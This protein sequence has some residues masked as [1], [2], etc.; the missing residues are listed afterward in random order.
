[1]HAGQRGRA[2]AL[3][4]GV[5]NHGNPRVGDVDGF[6]AAFVEGGVEVLV[7]K[8]AGAGEA[9]VVGDGKVRGDADEDGG[10][11]VEET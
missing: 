4:D 6:V 9:G 11:E 8:A 3:L 2:S 7:K 5:R 10:W 1:M